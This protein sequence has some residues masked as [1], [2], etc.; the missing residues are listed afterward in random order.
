MLKWDSEYL[1]LLLEIHTKETMVQSLVVEWLKCRTS[2]VKQHLPVKLVIQIDANI[3]Y[4]I[5]VRRELYL[6]LD[7]HL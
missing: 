3:T 7:R 2:E 6:Q 4:A 1:A 5:V